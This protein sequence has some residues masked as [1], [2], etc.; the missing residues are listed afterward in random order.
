MTEERRLRRQWKVLKAARTGRVE[1][2][3]GI[4]AGDRRRESVTTSLRATVMPPPVRGWRMFRASPRMERPGIVFAT[5]GRKEFGMLRRA[6]PE[7]LVVLMSL[8][9][10]ARWSAASK[11]GWTHGGRSGSTCLRRWPLTPPLA[12]EAEGVLLGT[13]MRARVSCVP[14]W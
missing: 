2:R 11:E 8:G 1:A 7:E 14:I 9:R 13:S 3:E 12:T 4:E 10:S 5:A 6:G